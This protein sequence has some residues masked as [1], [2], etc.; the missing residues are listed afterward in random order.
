MYKDFAATCYFFYNCS[1][2]T[3]G[4]TIYSQLFPIKKLILRALVTGGN[5]F[6]YKIKKIKIRPSISNFIITAFYKNKI[7]EFMWAARHWFDILLYIFYFTNKRNVDKINELLNFSFF[8]YHVL[9][10][11]DWIVHS[12]RIEYFACRLY[13]CPLTIP[14]NYNANYPISVIYVKVKNKYLFNFQHIFANNTPS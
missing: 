3:H 13:Y 4:H 2:K 11:N 12:N 5:S 1:T 9:H 14:T 8:M 7:N 6:W 10:A